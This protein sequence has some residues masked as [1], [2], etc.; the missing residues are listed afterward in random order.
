MHEVGGRLMSPTARGGVSPVNASVTEMILSAVAAQ[1]GC[2]VLD[3]PPLFEAIDPEAVERLVA[4]DATNE[5][6]FRYLGY[7]VTAT[8][9]EDVRITGEDDRR[10]TRGW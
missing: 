2:D 1:R 3:L 6:T 8:S 5:V 4:C 7:E 9:R 10:R